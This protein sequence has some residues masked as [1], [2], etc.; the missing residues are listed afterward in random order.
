V[1]GQSL[2]RRQNGGQGAAKA[3]APFAAKFG[4]DFGVAILNAHK[5]DKKTNPP[6]RGNGSAGRLG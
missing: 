1:S 2:R 3:F 6:A 4:M 5:T